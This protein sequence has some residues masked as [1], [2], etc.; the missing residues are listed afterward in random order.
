M[1]TKGD[2]ANHRPQKKGKEKKKTNSKETSASQLSCRN[3][4]NP[5]T[6]YFLRDQQPSPHEAEHTGHSKRYMPLGRQGERPDAWW[7]VPRSK[8]PL[9]ATF[10]PMRTSFVI[11]AACNKI[12][13]TWSWT[14]KMRD[15]SWDIG[16]Q[17]PFPHKPCSL[18]S[19][20]SKKMRATDRERA[21]VEPQLG[22]NRGW[23]PMGGQGAV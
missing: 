3:P 4:V 9:L 21:F 20:T 22:P 11:D 17:K 5:Q 13:P 15:G 6:P 18:H 1:I 19:T 7:L 10:S 23:K 12:N 8:A 14:W 16:S 2:G